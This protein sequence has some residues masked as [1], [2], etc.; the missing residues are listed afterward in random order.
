MQVEVVREDVLSFKITN[1]SDN[2]LDT[3]NIV[4]RKCRREA[5]RKGFKNMFSP[6]EKKFIVEFT[7]RVLDTKDDEA[8]Y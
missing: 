8:K 6:E 3:F 5:L 2:S 7:G 4:L 1:D